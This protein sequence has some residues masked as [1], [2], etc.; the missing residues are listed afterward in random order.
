MPLFLSTFRYDYDVILLLSYSTMITKWPCQIIVTLWNLF[1]FSEGTLWPA[2][3]YQDHFF[4]HFLN[5]L[6]F[7]DADLCLSF[8]MRLYETQ[9]TK[10]NQE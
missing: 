10:C 7:I 3:S 4:P 6:L 1:I 2:I 8:Y 5:Q 9:L